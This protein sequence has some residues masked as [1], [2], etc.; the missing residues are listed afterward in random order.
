V[1]RRRV[2]RPPMSLGVRVPGRGHRISDA[3]ALKREST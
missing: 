1:N 3:N 2:E